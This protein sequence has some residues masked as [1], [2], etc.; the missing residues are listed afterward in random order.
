MPGLRVVADLAKREQGKRI[1]VCPERGLGIDDWNAQLADDSQHV[2]ALGVSQRPKTPGVALPIWQI[3]ELDDAS[4]SL[5][6]LF[7][8]RPDLTKDLE[9][10][11]L[12]IRDPVLFMRFGLAQQAESLPEC[13]QF[14]KVQDP[15]GHAG[16]RSL[17]TFE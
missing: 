4:P 9:I 15:A 11:R 5:G 6:P 2:V 14:R 3:H 1:A 17:S 8:Q 13:R 12:E 16:E 10:G 7:G